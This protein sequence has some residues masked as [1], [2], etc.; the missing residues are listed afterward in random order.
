MQATAGW[1]RVLL[2]RQGSLRSKVGAQ[3]WALRNSVSP[4][5]EFVG[6]SKVGTHAGHASL[7]CMC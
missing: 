3:M 2:A 4:L 1:A 6:H 7:G 5:K